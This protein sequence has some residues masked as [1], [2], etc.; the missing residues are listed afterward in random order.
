MRN[1]KIGLIVILCVI[2]LGLCGVLVRGI[3]YGN[4]G[5][6]DAKADAKGGTE[7]H[8]VLE[9]EVSLSGI[10]TISV[11]Y[12]MNSNDV[13][14]HAGEGD[15]LLVKEYIGYEAKESEISTVTVSGSALEIKGKKRGYF[16]FAGYSDGGGY[17]ELWLPVSYRGNIKIAMLSG[18]IISE[19]DLTLGG[20]FSAA[21]TSGEII[22]QDISADRVS[23]STTSGDIR[24]AALTGGT[25]ISTTSGRVSVEAISGAASV[26][27]TS[28]DVYISRIEGDADLST[29]SGVVAVDAGSGRRGVSTTSG[30]I[31]LVWTDGDFDISTTSGEVS[32]NVEAGAGRIE[33][34]SGDIRLELP[35]LT[36]NLLIDT[37]SGE[38]S[39]KLSG[40]NSFEFAVD[41][42]SGGISTF[43][44]D[45]L[46]FSKKGNYAQGTVGNDTQGRRV[47][48]ETT[49]GDV[50]VAE[51]Q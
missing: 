1:I 9:E 7:M 6:L 29:V 3:A 44:D 20:T 4:G 15:T 17:T 21:S 25:D 13:I 31:R 26:S 16:G 2:A 32:V 27:A 39:V 5:G 43:F 10:D 46:T 14:L 34:T 30:D 47:D 35:L 41:T 23:F 38:V 37:T 8:L 12:D 22:T 50:R 18:V 33:S 48:I 51:Y 36:G 24:A 28:G 42:T 45:S 40:D 49:S 19:F 11:L